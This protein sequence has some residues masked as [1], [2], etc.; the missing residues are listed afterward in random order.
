MNPMELK[1]ARIRRGKTKGDMARLFGITDAA[2]T[3][4]EQGQTRMSV[5][6]A[7]KISRFLGLSE[8]EFVTIFF[9][10]V[11]PFGNKTENIS[12]S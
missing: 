7:V 8:S 12:F 2:W 4:R 6:E 9:D 5:D 10:G 3:K 1:V 11:L